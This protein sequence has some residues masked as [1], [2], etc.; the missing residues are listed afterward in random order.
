MAARPWRCRRICSAER[1]ARAAGGVASASHALSPVWDDGGLP[2]SR[3]G[4]GRTHDEEAVDQAISEALPDLQDR[5]AKREHGSGA[6]R[7]DMVLLAVACGH[8]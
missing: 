3:F 2:V 5:G 8:L 7:W 4:R 6:R 1:D